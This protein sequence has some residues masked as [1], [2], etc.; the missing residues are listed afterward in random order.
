MMKET[1]RPAHPAISIIVP[2]YNVKPYLDRCVSSVLAQ[3]FTDWELMLIDD[4]STDGSG[5]VCDACARRDPRVRVIHQPNSGVSAARNRGLDKARGEYVMFLD[6][7]DYYIDGEALEKL[8]NC[9]ETDRLDWLRGEYVAVDEEGNPLPPSLTEV[10]G[11]RRK[12][13]GRVLDADDFLS[14]VIRGEFFSVLMLFRRKCLDGCRFEAGRVFLEDMRFLLNALRQDGRYAYMDLPFYAYRKWVGSVS[15]Q[16]D[17]RKLGDSFDMCDWLA[18]WAE[19]FPP[20]G[21]RTWGRYSSVMIYYRTLQTLAADPFYAEMESIANGLGLASLQRR[22]LRRLGRYRVF[23]LYLPF[24][25][26]PVGWSC[27]LMRLKDHVMIRL[28]GLN[29]KPWN[30]QQ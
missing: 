3:T 25:V 26:L 14:H 29:R 16:A 30:T 15:G 20:G 11:L 21:R 22:T 18:S 6:A 17:V 13:V 8:Y 4:G 28:H 5:E 23:N 12:Y 10:N 7:D 9:A 27:K 2:V 19:G 24:F 1:A